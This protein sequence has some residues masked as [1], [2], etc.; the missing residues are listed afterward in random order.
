[1]IDEALLSADTDVSNTIGLSP[2]VM[3][4]PSWTKGGRSA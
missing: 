4:P 2:R 1:M 3:A